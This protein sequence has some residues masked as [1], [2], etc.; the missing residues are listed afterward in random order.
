VD[1]YAVPDAVTCVSVGFLIA[2]TDAALALAAN[3]G[4]IGHDRSQACGIIR[5]PASAVRRLA[6]L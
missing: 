4:D 6:D 2:Q 5:I 3:L 1:E